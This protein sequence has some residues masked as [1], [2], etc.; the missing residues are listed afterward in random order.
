M[1]MIYKYQHRRSNTTL[2]SPN[3]KIV[4]DNTVGVSIRAVVSPS[5]HEYTEVDLC[6]THSYGGF[7]TFCELFFQSQTMYL[8]HRYSDGA[9]RTIVSLFYANY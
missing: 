3:C 7:R 5:K 8:Y 2:S 1:T 6:Q 9:A 4:V